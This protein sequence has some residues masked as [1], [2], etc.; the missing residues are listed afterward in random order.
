MDESSIIQHITETFDGIDVVHASGNTFFFYDPG[1]E[2][3]PSP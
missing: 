3:P 2:S 1:R